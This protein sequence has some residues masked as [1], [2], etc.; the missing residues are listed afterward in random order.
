MNL[1]LFCSRDVQRWC[2]IA[3]L[4]LVETVIWVGS[5]ES[6]IIKLPL[7]VIGAT[8]AAALF[9]TDAII[10]RNVEIPIPAAAILVALH[11]PLF[12]CSALFSFDTVYTSRALGFGIGCVISFFAGSSL[13]GTRKETEV[14]F[15]LLEILT[16]VLCIV[17]MI[18]FFLGE[19]LPL[20]F[21]TGAQH[22][23]SSLLGNSIYFS[24]LLVLWF[25]ILLTRTL[26]TDSGNTLRML[27]WAEL[28]VTTL[29]LG[30][31]QTRSSIVGWLAALAVLLLLLSR[32][33]KAR[34][35][36]VAS[37]LTLLAIVAYAGFIQPDVGQRYLSMFGERRGTAV[38]RRV[39][40]WTAG[41]D[42]FLASP[43]FGHGIGSFERAVFAYRSP[44]YWE[45]GSEDVVPHAHNEMVEIAVEYGC[46][47]LLLF[48]ATFGLVLRE[49]VRQARGEDMWKRLTSAGITG[50]L[51]GIAVDNLANVSLRQPPIALLVW[52]LLGLLFSGALK[53]EDAKT[54]SARIPFP[55][56]AAGVP[57][58]L[59]A[60]LAIAYG[61][62]E[63]HAISADV[64]FL[65]GLNASD[66][67]SG[68]ALG[69]FQA[70]VMEDPA[71][72]RARLYQIKELLDNERWEDALQHVNALQQLS[73]MY[74]KSSLMG[75]YALLRL[76]RY[77]EALESIHKELLR[78]THPEA[79]MVQAATYR[80][81]REAGAERDAIRN[82][83]KKDIEGRIPYEFGASCRRLVELCEKESERQDADSLFTSLERVF[84][85]EREFFDGLKSQMRTAR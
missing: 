76:G 57:L 55:R 43:V 72:L 30:I 48:V 58:I 40:F 54:I 67:S 4:L 62:K 66:A 82:L 6:G 71:N 5:T 27:R 52:V 49:G 47:G 26:R 59:W 23:P 53:G 11:L 9:L 16:L 3:T 42:A 81:L 70:A 85:G 12:L 84:P 63:V 24:S 38:A 21:S 44:D 69:E 74:P 46:I 14:F 45:A 20:D 32:S 51:V 39:V 29:A 60:T 68:T 22:R 10:K 65:R 15:N 31:T 1:P 64:H 36:I 56:L 78:R 41:T 79:Y 75:A 19:A 2:I 17:A 50:G 28:A 34:I 13:F 33:G 80:A 35:S 61:T 73:P 25:P 7:F 83:L 18:Q 77:H 37:S 8:L